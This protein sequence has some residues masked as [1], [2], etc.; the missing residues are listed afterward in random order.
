MRKL[1]LAVSTILAVAAFGFTAMAGFS[2]LPLTIEK[3]RRKVK[4]VCNIND[5][6]CVPLE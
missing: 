4:K 2:T 6:Y 1:R 3:Y 5:K